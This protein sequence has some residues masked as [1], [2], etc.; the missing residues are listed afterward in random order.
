[1]SIPPILERQPDFPKRYIG[2]AQSA[3]F[4]GRTSAHIRK[5]A[6]SVVYTDFL[7]MYPTVNS[8]MNL[9]KFVTAEEVV[10][11]E[12][13]ADSTYDWLT[14]LNPPLLFQQ[15]TWKEL[16]AFV[17]VIPNG[18]IL[19]SRGRY[20]PETNDWQV[21]INH[22][23]A[24]DAKQNRALWFSLP[25]VAASVL[26]TGRVPTIVDA[27]RLIP[28]GKLTGLTPTK[29]RGMI[30]VDPADEDFFRV[31]IQERIGL[32][33]RTDLSKVEKSRLKKA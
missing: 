20:N 7:S 10:V 18:E 21:A 31:V 14:E 11:Q 13:C 8:L 2:H 29:L 33:G 17:Q 19:P 15:Q 32:G 23:Y 25:D 4:G 22:V 6:V 1:M 27:F 5:V 30:D 28:K 9:W 26:L 12:H 16:P 24:G 3:F